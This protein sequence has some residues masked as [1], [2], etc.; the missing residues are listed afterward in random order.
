MAGA[1]LGP[2]SG[3]KIYIGTK[4]TTGSDDAYT[5]IGKVNNQ[6]AFGPVYQEIKFDT[7]DNRDTLKFKGQRDDGNIALTLGRDL[8]D[9]GQ[10]AL[11]AALSDDHDYNFKVTLND[12]GVATGALPTTY[13][14]KAKVMSFTT[15][16]GATNQV[17][18]AS[19]SIAIKS[20]SIVETAAT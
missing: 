19:V 6:G 16:I 2:S 12:A 17:V 11:T 13:L 9:T 15:N 8:T 3:A 18:Q 20:G 5:L 1:G 10:L 7:L 14:F 4:Q